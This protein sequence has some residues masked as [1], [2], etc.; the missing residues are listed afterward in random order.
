VQGASQ[1]ATRHGGRPRTIASTVAVE[2]S[3]GP[4]VLRRCCSRT[5]PAVPISVMV[6]IPGSA[7]ETHFSLTRQ[8]FRIAE[9]G[10][11]FAPSPPAQL[12]RHSA[13]PESGVR[14]LQW[15]RCVE[16]IHKR[17]PD[18]GLLALLRLELSDCGSAARNMTSIHGSMGTTLALLWRPLNVTE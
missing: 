10:A 6:A 8:T 9:D 15:L 14:R 1:R 4:V 11:A 12:N 5:P 18:Y 2:V 17:R 13:V 3:H 7:A 16:T